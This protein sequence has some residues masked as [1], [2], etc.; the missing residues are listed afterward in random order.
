MKILFIA[1]VV[2]CGCSQQRMNDM[3]K[4]FEQ[5]RCTQQGGWYQWDSGKCEFPTQRIVIVRE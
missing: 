5:N 2:L 3:A 1:I 4:G